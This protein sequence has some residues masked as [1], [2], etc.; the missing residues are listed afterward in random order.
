MHN[1]GIIHRDLSY[2]NIMF[3]ES[4]STITVLDFG[5]SIFEDRVTNSLGLDDINIDFKD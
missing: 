3:N 1:Y 4:D 2:S 5:L